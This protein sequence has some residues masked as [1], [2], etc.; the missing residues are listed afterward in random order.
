MFFFFSEMVLS[1][2]CGVPTVGYLYNI[3]RP[4]IARGYDGELLPRSTGYDSRLL[5]LILLHLIRYRLPSSV[6]E[7]SLLDILAYIIYT[8][9][10]VQNCFFISCIS[11]R[12]VKPGYNVC[13]TGIDIFKLIIIGYVECER[14]NQ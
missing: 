5:N 11:F 6:N 4:H 1:K 7:C 13:I 12:Q 14:G 3:G 10:Y 9:M 2:P 8:H